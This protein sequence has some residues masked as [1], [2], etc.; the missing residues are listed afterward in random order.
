MNGGPRRRARAAE[1]I[2]SS[3]LHLAYIAQSRYADHLPPW[4]EQFGR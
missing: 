1:L 3:P 2:E 4:L